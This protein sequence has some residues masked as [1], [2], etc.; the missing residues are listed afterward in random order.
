MHSFSNLL[1]RKRTQST[2]YAGINVLTPIFEWFISLMPNTTI[3]RYFFMTKFE[4][5]QGTEWY[6][7]TIYINGMC[8]NER[9]MEWG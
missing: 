9:C 2:T 4:M 6:H 1:C 5:E 3:G 7:A 8:I